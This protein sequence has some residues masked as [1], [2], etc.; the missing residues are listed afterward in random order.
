MSN[1]PPLKVS[2]LIAGGKVREQTGGEAV[3]FSG[4]AD[5]VSAPPRDDN[6]EDNRV[7]DLPCDLIDDSPYQNPNRIYDPE[8]LDE[9]GGAMSTAGQ[10]EPIQVRRKGDRY[11]LIAGHRRIR[12]ARLRGWSRIKAVVLVMDD[13]QAELATLTHNEGR[14]DLSDFER[15]KAYQYA[16][17][18][19]HGKQAQIAMLFATS[20]TNVSR[21]LSMLKLP[22]PIVSLLEAQPGLFGIKTTEIINQLLTNHP[23]EEDLIVQAVQRLKSGATSASIKGWF[24]QM[25]KQAARAAS[26][27]SNKAKVITNKSGRQLFTAKRDGRVI[28]VR[29]SASDVDADDTMLK[30]IESLKQFTG[31]KYDEK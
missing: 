29:I 7:I 10:G 2:G 12:A 26:P 4:S 13:K 16:I 9:L 30:V 3:S 5:A 19:G 25:H 14:K 31:E 6:G 1:R 23:N 24:E 15:G 27:A 20:T 8:K 18:R 28:T 21:C 11:Q 17:E 22:K